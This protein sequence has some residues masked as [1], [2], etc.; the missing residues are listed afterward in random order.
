MEYIHL[1]S[2]SNIDLLSARLRG[3]ACSNTEKL[4]VVCPGCEPNWTSPEI[5]T[6]FVDLRHVGNLRELKLNCVGLLDVAFPLQ[7]LKDVVENTSSKMQSLELDD[8]ALTTRNEEEV[9]ALA[10]AIQAKAASGQWTEF[11]L[12][13]CLADDTLRPSAAALDPLW[14]SLATLQRVELDAVD[15]GLLGNI[16]ASTVGHLVRSKTIQHFHLNGFALDNDCLVELAEA[17][18][19]NTRLED[20]SLDLYS[21]GHPGKGAF[22]LAESLRMNQHL[23]RL[24]LSISH[25]WNDECFLKAVANALTTDCTLESLIIGTCGMIRDSTAKAFAEMMVRN[26]TLEL[27]QLSRY[28]GEWKPILTYYL[29]LNSQRRGYYHSNYGVLCKKQ[30]VEGLVGVRDDLD[31]LY[32]FLHMN[33]SIYCGKYALVC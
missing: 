2:H 21:V 5:K 7:L 20:L 22:A 31:G 26:Y 12:F 19:C 8:V 9:L 30:W 27:L 24:H 11:R 32:Y 29:L 28:S 16:K 23:K 18:E 10:K 17:L 33:P 3:S 25:S 14:A 13:G 4:I 15:D 6:L 1:R